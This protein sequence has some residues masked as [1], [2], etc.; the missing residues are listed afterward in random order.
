MKKGFKTITARE[1]L[2][3]GIV[4]LLVMTGLLVLL[5]ITGYLFA[6]KT[7]DRIATAARE[8]FISQPCLKGDDIQV[9]AQDGAVTLTGI[10]DAGPDASLAA[11]TVADLP[12]VKRVDN[13]I[14][15]KP[16]AG[17]GAKSSPASIFRFSLHKA[18]K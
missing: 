3:P 8:A 11:E 10:V 15:V 18:T 12:G 5:M 13:L 4:S 17:S 1:A 2:I 9:R 6:V 7:D 16:P 14:E